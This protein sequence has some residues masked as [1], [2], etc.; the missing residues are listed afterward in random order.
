MLNM[1]YNPATKG[2][3]YGY[4][5]PEESNSSIQETYNLPNQANVG[6]YKP[7]DYPRV[8]SDV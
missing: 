6:M 5:I 7:K 1:L 3:T 2:D 8:S 4:A